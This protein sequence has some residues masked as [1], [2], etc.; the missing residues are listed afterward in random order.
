MSWVCRAPTELQQVK[1]GTESCRSVLNV[2]RL[3]TL[4]LSASIIAPQE[5]EVLGCCLDGY[6]IRRGVNLGRRWGTNGAPIYRHCLR[7]W[8]GAAFMGRAKRR[9]RCSR[10]DDLSCGEVNQEP[11]RSSQNATS[12]CLRK[13][14]M[15][16]SSS[17]DKLVDFGS[18]GP[19][20][21]SATEPRFFHFATV[22][23]LI[24]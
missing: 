4:P 15:M 13:A 2:F 18:F 12:V 11:G 22:F 7:G 5:A 16:A 3:R 17:S 8:I 23:G 21:R 14:T 20:E 10:A 1:S 6:V 19:V 9:R 24:L